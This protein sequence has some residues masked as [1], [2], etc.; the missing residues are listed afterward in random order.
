MVG[1][2]V[3]GIYD[4]KPYSP[5]SHRLGAFGGY[6][7]DPPGP[8]EDLEMPDLEFPPIF[9]G[10]TMNMLVSDFREGLNST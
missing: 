5:G 4:I 8:L 3:P 1:L 6:R 10:K 2:G 7:V 9:W